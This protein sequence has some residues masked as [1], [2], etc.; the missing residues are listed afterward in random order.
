MVKLVFVIAGS[1]HLWLTSN[2]CFI[3]P[4][5]IC[6]ASSLM[7]CAGIYN[8]SVNTFSSS[9][10]DSIFEWF[11]GQCRQIGSSFFVFLNKLRFERRKQL[12]PNQLAMN[13][14]PLVDQFGSAFYNCLSLSCSSIASILHLTM[15]ITNF[16]TFLLSLLAYLIVCPMFHFEIMEWGAG[17]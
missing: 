12:M 1:M 3:F 6:H 17:N 14:A 16:Q 13:N 11:W 4:Q 7:V 5:F 2:V 9:L 15:V 8:L 10:F